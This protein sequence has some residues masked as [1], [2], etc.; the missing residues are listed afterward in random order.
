MKMF[1]FQACVMHGESIILIPWNTGPSLENPILFNQ[2][3]D[4]IQQLKF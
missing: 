1:L 3:I 4:K 2:H